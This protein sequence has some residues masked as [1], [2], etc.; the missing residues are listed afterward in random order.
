MRIYIF[1]VVCNVSVQ[2]DLGMQ[3]DDPRWFKIFSSSVI[4]AQ[5]AF[6]NDDCV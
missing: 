6:E 5:A 3:R 4:N 2:S 1:Y